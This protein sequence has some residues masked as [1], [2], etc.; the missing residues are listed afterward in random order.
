MPRAQ[1]IPDQLRPDLERLILTEKQPHSVVLNWLAEQGI[2]CQARTLRDYCK[3]WNLSHPVASEAVVSFID[4]QFH[5][6]L[7]DDAT[8]A[9]EL[10][11]RGF[12][13]SARQVRSIRTA[14]GWK[15]RTRDTAERQLNWSETFDRVGQALAEGTVRS[16]GREM[17]YSNLRRQQGY[18]ARQDDVRNA[19]KLQDPVGTETRKP[20]AKRKRR[21]EYIVPGPNFLWSI[22]GH[23]KLASY[24][25][26]IYAAIDAYSRRIL[27]FYVG[28]SNRTQ[29]SVVRQFLNAVQHYNLC[30]DYIRS[31]R[32]SE[33]PLVADAQYSFYI[34]RRRADGV[35]EDALESIPLRECY[36][37]GTSTLN[38]RIERFWRSLIDGMT[39]PWMVRC[40]D[41]IGSYDFI[42]ISAQIRA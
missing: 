34:Q 10:N 36:F 17:V 18:R 6:T 35:P 38:V 25:I 9:R 8:I 24:G 2:V 20:G 4:T 30:P 26:E 13:V 21:L 3:R 40:I 33:T 5:T 32:G 42:P 41:F 11:D 19:L 15:H 23:D 7:N 29:L 31:D 28:N 14:K 12:P 16:Y 22:D 1:A 37:Y 27:W 39:L